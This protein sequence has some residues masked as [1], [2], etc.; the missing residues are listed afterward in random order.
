MSVVSHDPAHGA[1]LRNASR[2]PRPTSCAHRA[3][4]SRRRHRCS[5]R[6]PPPGAVR[7]LH[8]LA[9]ALEAH[10][11]RARRHWPTGRPALGE[12]RLDRRGGSYRRP[13]AFLRRR[14]ASKVPTW[15]VTVDDAT[16]TTPR[17]VRRQP[18]A[19]PGRRLRRQQLSVRLR[20]AGQ[21][22]RGGARCRLPGRGQ[23]A[24][25]AHRPDRAPGRDRACR[26][27]RGGRARG[28]LRR[29]WSATTP[30]WASSRPPRSPRWPSPARRHGGL[31]LWRI[32]NEREVVIPVFAEMG[33]V[34]PVVVTP[35]RRRRH[36]LGRARGSSD[37]S[38]WGTASSAPSRGSCWHRPAAVQ[39]TPSPP[40]CATL[41]P[42]P[43]MLT[44]SIAESVAG[45]IERAG[46]RRG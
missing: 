12:Q 32:A 44:R 3:A 18:P 40:H 26:A 2:R 11:R 4:R 25:R 43:V 30:A 35:R 19:G 29:W 7:W 13:A 31:A 38:P 46:G 36:G 23:G 8:G 34:N 42:S 33:T 1:M 15:A 37:R 24:P 45:G 16:G 20:R 14:G 27:R 17:L 28:D 39:P 9:D 6:R 22:H 10:G 5:R 41:A 21:R